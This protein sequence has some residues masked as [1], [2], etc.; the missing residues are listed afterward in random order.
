MSRTVHC[1]KLGTDAEGL[2]RP[3]LPGPMGQRIF[4]NVS[5]QA[6]QGWI[7]HQTRLINE[8][9]LVLADAQS[10]RFLS[11]E[12]ERYFFGDGKTSETGYVPPSE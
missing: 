5:K 9:R 2:D 1:I 10:R 7:E 11:Q 4:E 12:M 8:Y 3:P 6:W